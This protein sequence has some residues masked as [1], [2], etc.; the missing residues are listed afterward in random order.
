MLVSTVW[1][2]SHILISSTDIPKDTARIC[3]EAF[4][5]YVYP[6]PGLCFIHRGTLMQTFLDGTLNSKL[7]LAICGVASRFT[8]RVLPCFAAAGDGP[9]WLEAAEKQILQSPHLLRT[10]VAALALIAFDHGLSRRFSRL[11]GVLA[12]AI[13]MAYV[14]RLNHEDKD[15]S[16]EG[17]EWRRRIMWGLWMMETTSC[18]DWPNLSFCRTESIHLQL[19]CNERSFN[20]NVPVD[21]GSLR[22]QT[23]DPGKDGYGL[24]TYLVRIHDIRRRTSTVVQLEN[25][26][27]DFEQE[28]ESFH[29]LLPENH[30]MNRRNLSRRIYLP[31]RTTFVMLHI[32]WHETYINLYC[33]TLNKIDEE[34]TWPVSDPPATRPIEYYR[35]RYLQHAVAMSTI[36]STILSSDNTVCISDPLLADCAWSAVKAITLT[37]PPA[38]DGHKAFNPVPHLQSCADILMNSAQFYPTTMMVRERI[39]DILSNMEQIL[40]HPQLASLPMNVSSGTK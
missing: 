1:F 30:V 7:L 8:A 3:I 12:F 39:I 35:S 22:Q 2:T 34:E 9:K 18:D 15:I 4:F 36:F 16:F 14:M 26:I 29:R 20:I 31:S 37:K 25:S 27:R 33:E 5:E 40:D 21:V 6:I 11:M 28:L 17:Q 19:P 23:Q 32:W 13:R 24:A 38:L 10:D